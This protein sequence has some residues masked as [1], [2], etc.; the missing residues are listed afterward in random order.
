M[1]ATLALA[2]ME[3]FANEKERIESRPV[4]NFPSLYDIHS[5]TFIGSFAWTNTVEK[6]KI[7]DSRNGILTGVGWQ[8]PAELARDYVASTYQKPGRVKTTQ[9]HEFM[10][11]RTAPM[12]ARPG[13]YE[14]SL[15][16]DLKSAYWSI[17][18]VIGWDVD[19][20]PGKWLSVKSDN[21]DFPYWKNKLARNCLV[22]VGVVGQ[23]RAWTGEKL[24][25]HKKQN[26]YTNMM[27]WAAVQDVLAGV[28]FDMKA[29]GAVYIHTDGY[30]VKRSDYVPAMEVFDRWGLV[31]TVRSEGK[32]EVIGAGTY[33]S[34]NKPNNRMA[35]MR[36]KAFENINPVCVDW[37]RDRFSR[38]AARKPLLLG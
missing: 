33:S 2:R 17:L 22:S 30:I 9:Y 35:N 13:V 4:D 20:F 34:P 19:Y 11:H 21:R 37:L 6:W 5:F 1:L 18:Q 32:H 12:F 24:V 27:L 7:I 28:A 14:D 29:A 38:F 26:K 10:R 16:L 3:D 15:Y 25:F 36:P 23:G 8:T 31:G